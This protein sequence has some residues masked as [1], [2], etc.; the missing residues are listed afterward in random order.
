LGVLAAAGFAPMSRPTNRQL[1]EHIHELIHHEERG[2]L[3]ELRRI[4]KELRKLMTTVPEVNAK[5]D[6]ALAKLTANTDALKGISDYIAAVRVELA[7]VKQQLQ[8]LIDAGNNP[9]E[10]TEVVAKL[11]ALDAGLDA[12]AVKEAAVVNTPDDPND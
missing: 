12:Q 3:T 5:L 4:K 9:P 7:A 6:A 1:L 8:D 10:L 2:L 11:D